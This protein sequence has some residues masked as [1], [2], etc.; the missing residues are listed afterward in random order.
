MNAR[1]APDLLEEILALKHQ[2][3]EYLQ[4]VNKK[5]EINENIIQINIGD[6]LEKLI[7]ERIARKEEEILDYAIRATQKAKTQKIFPDS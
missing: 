1:E 4:L 7:L 5:H 2:I 6:L 3:N